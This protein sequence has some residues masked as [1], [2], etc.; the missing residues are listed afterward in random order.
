MD[1]L[2]IDNLNDKQSIYEHS[3]KITK[4]L[5]ENIKLT[6]NNHDELKKML[7]ILESIKE[8]NDKINNRL[9]DV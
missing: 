2:D 4:I 1:L 6:V 5:N 8:I 7:F 9:K 3:T